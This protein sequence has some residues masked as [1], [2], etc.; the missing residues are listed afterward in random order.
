MPDAKSVAL[1]EVAAWV[2]VRDGI[3]RARKGV[4][5]VLDELRQ[6]GSFIVLDTEA[7]IQAADV[8]TRAE[9]LQ[10][11][12]TKVKKSGN[13][14]P[15]QIH[16]AR[17]EAVSALRQAGRTTEARTLQQ[18]VVDALVARKK[19]DPD[20]HVQA[21]ILGELMVEEGD[22]EAGARRL[23]S[24]VVGLARTV[25]Q[26]DARFQSANERLKAVESRE[27]APEH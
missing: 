15:T 26:H 21:A 10:E 18:S 20:T 1:H 7:R 27:L 5:A 12:A 24:A 23:R 14:T 2:D 6:A 16:H 3:L 13:A 9:A 17:S 8:D 19:A 22:A 4:E 25:G 11:A